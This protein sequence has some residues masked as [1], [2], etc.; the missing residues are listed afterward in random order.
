MAAKTEKCFIILKPDE[1][2]NPV[3]IFPETELAEMLEDYSDGKAVTIN[4]VLENTDPNYWDEEEFFVA[5][6]IPVKLK[7]VSTL[8]VDK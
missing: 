4:Y 7:K 1:D 2:G 3:R 8:L 6:I 5:E